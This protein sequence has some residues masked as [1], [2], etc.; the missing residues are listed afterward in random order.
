MQFAKGAT[1]V[2][3]AWALLL[4]AITAV[5]EPTQMVIVVGPK[6][7]SM[8]ALAGSDTRLV[9]SGAGYIVV[10]GTER[11]FVRALYAGGALLV[12][13]KRSAGG[14]LGLKRDGA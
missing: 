4:A 10:S 1:I 7:R 3:A 5:A 12:L 13:P 6:D 8:A 11:G 2:L 9:D 14:C